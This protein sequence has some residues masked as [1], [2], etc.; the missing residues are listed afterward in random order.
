M[1]GPAFI[2]AVLATAASAY[3]LTTWSKGKTQTA[4]D[5]KLAL[6]V[7]ASTEWTWGLRSPVAWAEYMKFHEAVTWIEELYTYWYFNTG[8]QLSFTKSDGTI[9][10]LFGVRP[11]LNIMDIAFAEMMLMYWQKESEHCWYGGWWMEFMYLFVDIDVATRECKVGT[12]DYLMKDGK[13][14]CFTSVYS[15]AEVYYKPLTKIARYNEGRYD[16]GWNTCQDYPAF[17]M[18]DT[19][20]RSITE[21]LESVQDATSDEMNDAQPEE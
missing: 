18:H 4:L 2:S 17:K 6:T 10:F 13:F 20:V 21:A 16:W 3:Q 19:E 5:G 14:K 8:A 9:L 11:Y 12:H 15:V 7:D 1:D